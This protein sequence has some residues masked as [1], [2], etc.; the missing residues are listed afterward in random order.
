[1]AV[2]PLRA[3][4]FV[5]AASPDRLEGRPVTRSDLE[6][7][8][9]R[10]VRATVL[11]AN[12]AG[13]SALSVAVGPERAYFATTGLLNALD[14]VVRSHGGAVDKYLGDALLAVFGHPL[15]IARPAARA[16]SAALE[17]QRLT[18]EYRR[19]VADA[20]SLQLTIG[21][22][23]GTMVVGDVAGPAVREFHVL[24]GAVNVAARMRARAPLGGVLAGPDTVREAGAGFEVRSLGSLAFKGTSEPIQTFEVRGSHGDAAGLETELGSLPLVGREAERK[25]VREAAARAAQGAPVGVLVSGPPG[26]GKTRILSE[27]AVAAAEAGCQ[28]LRTSG[29]GPVR[30]LPALVEEALASAR[31]TGAVAILIDD[32]DR[33][34]DD[35]ARAG[36]LD[37]AAW[38]PASGGLLVA[39]SAV[40][41]IPCRGGFQHIALGPL[42]EPGAR[43]LLGS[44]SLPEPLDEESL[45][46]VLEH[47]AGLPEKLMLA[48][49]A[50]PAL[51]QDRTRRGLDGGDEEAERRRATILFADITGFTRLTER[52]GAERAYPVVARCLAL[53]DEITRKHGGTVEKYLGDC[54]MALFGV[55]EA[56]EDAP[57]AAVNAAIEMRR[58]VRELSAS[59]PGEVELDLHC[60]IHTG[61]GIA[62]DLRGPLIRES[63]VMGDPV[64]VADGLK[65]MAPSGAIFV[66]EESRR[67]TADAFEYRPA[68]QLE[69][70]GAAASEPAYE[71]CST[72]ERLGRARVGQERRVFAPLVGRDRERSALLERVAALAE[73]RGGIVS[74]VAE[75]GIGKS[76][77]L[78]EIAGSPAAGQVIWREGVALSTGQRTGFGCIADLLRSWSGADDDDDEAGLWNKLAALVDAFVPPGERDDVLPFLGVLLGARLPE[79]GRERIARLPSDALEKLILGSLTRLLRGASSRRPLALVIDDAHWADLSSIGVLEAL[80]RLAVER[81]ILFVNVFRPGF[82]ATS[83]RL[84]RL[85]EERF[86]SHHLELRLAPLG[87]DAARALLRHLF[88]PGG[89]PHATRQ[90]IEEKSGGNPFYIE[91]VVRA[92]V[93]AGAVEHR[94]GLFRATEKIDT[95]VVPG[96]VQEVV[97]ARLDGLPR[98]R[99]R[100][101]QA[102]S[103]IGSVFHLDVLRGVVAQGDLDAEIDELQAGEFLVESDRLPGQ[104]FAFKHPLLRDVTY[105]GLLEARREELHGAVGR[106]I[107]AALPETLPGYYGMLAFHFSKARLV[108]R[109]EEYL[110]RAGDEAARAAAPSEALD[111]FQEAFALYLGAHGDA[112]DP[113]K[114]VQLERNIAN[115]LYFRGRFVEAIQHYNRALARL[116]DRPD[117]G[118]L[119][120]TLAFAGHLIA[121]LARLYVPLPRRQRPVTEAERAVLDLRYARAEATVTAE[122]TRH[123]MNGVETLARLQSLDPRTVPNS[124]KM[125]AGAVGLFAYG[126]LSFSVSR[127]LAEIAASL[128]RDG[129]LS[130]RLY[131]RVMRFAARV[132]EGDWSPEHEVPT[133]L[134]EAGLGVGQPWGPVTYLGLLG[135]KQIRSG[136][137]DGAARSVEWIGRI[138][139]LFQYDLARANFY[140]LGMLLPL[141]RRRLAEA[142]EA[143]DR[144]YEENPESLL[145]LLA[146]SGRAKAE[147][148]LGR[149]EDAEETMRRAEEVFRRSAPVPPFHA[150][151]YHASRVYVALARLESGESGAGRRARAAMRRSARREARSALRAS[152][153][154]AWW[155]PEV[156]RLCARVARQLGA[157]RRSWAHLERSIREAERLGARVEAARSRLLA[158]R[159]LRQDPRGP[160]S[161]AGDTAR[162]LEAAGLDALPDS[163]AF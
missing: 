3:L 4:W 124:G 112:A 94:E 37:P 32:F 118:E 25:E 157:R 85:A 159:W 149:T 61:L 135:E 87:A 27:L 126:G 95:F 105:D 24:G 125:Y 81:P 92:L 66:G 13:F 123:V 109:A 90:L 148:L 12:I 117:R 15:P 55:S 53:L 30:P 44:L 49:Y 63:A 58:R 88:G 41:S 45:R 54:V 62:G 103:V 154:V 56:I 98:P 10:T 78:S 52:M 69:L 133:D 136:D 132:L 134:I 138:W 122:P 6:A 111:F 155:R 57:R 145:H 29:A 152:R 160:S 14:G 80:M 119:A 121:V 104:E 158:A 43:A 67:F 75:A 131:E 36:F 71:L 146:L 82:E 97:T 65:D 113:G 163:D 35:A 101:L 144:Y 28:V 86:A 77:L 143:A 20:A 17:M 114:L 141:D 48:A 34:P 162:A 161:L 1:L 156:E 89:L 16:L 74:L 116:G 153:K 42:A 21:V 91:E 22:N 18:E 11:F 100:I 51:R 83:E 40:R 107:E 76:R 64:T 140:Y 50:A 72:R 73:G 128:A 33:L 39:L 142:V 130:E 70:P 47:G 5:G 108:E 2:G 150:S 7:D 120:R 46:L 110:L 151:S 59:T 68:G 129:E 99:R 96:S 19:Q 106:Q 127:R 102:A 60:G 93:D 26:V 115:A 38:P 31:G 147:V 23:T 79:T 84:R 8:G 139:D 137:Y 9:P